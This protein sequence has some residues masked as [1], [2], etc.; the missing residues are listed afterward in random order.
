M[1]EISLKSRYAKTTFCL[2]FVDIIAVKK[3]PLVVESWWDCGRIFGFVEIKQEKFRC[4][5]MVL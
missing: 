5:V 1:M 3:R 4:F 2:V